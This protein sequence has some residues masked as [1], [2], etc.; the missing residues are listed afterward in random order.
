MTGHT[1][2]TA[3]DRPPSTER[4][5]LLATLGAAA[6][7]G[8]VA[9]CVSVG[10]SGDSGGTENENVVLEPPE[11]YERLST[12]EIDFPIHGEPLPEVTVEA[13]LR[14][15]TVTTTS[16][17]GDRHVMT[18][19][20]F[21][22]CSMACPA[23]TSNLVQ[24]QATA[25]QDGFADE[26]AFLPMTFDPEYDTADRIAAYLDERGVDRSAGNW[27]FLRP[28]GPNRAREVVA[29]SFGVFY[30][31][32]PEAKRDM[33]NMAWTHSNLVVLANADG[34]V[35]RAYRGQ[36]PNPATVVDDVQT[37]RDR[38]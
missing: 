13:P 26:F 35:E 12:A 4:R 2:R 3:T 31:F 19:F 11:N 24:V 8:A 6:L 9:G 14:G 20:V 30:E 37:L 18:T 16:F 22:R 32:V 27:W 25:N 7:G 15:Q 28:A 38:W 33:D 10:E 5:T 29:D 36:P 23:L 1:D 21:T 17:V 34:Y